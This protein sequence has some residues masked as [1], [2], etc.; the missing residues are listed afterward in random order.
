[1]PDEYAFSAPPT[2]ADGV[3]YTLG[4]GN[5]GILY[6]V[7]ESDGSLLWTANIHVGDISSPAVSGDTVAVAD[8]C[9]AYGFSLA[10]EERWIY[11]KSCT[12][13][14]GANVA[15][16]EDLLYSRATG[17]VALSMA[18]GTA[19]GGVVSG[20][21]PAFAG[22]LMY[23][24]NAGRI[25]AIRVGTGAGRW[26]VE[27]ADPIV[28]APLVM[29]DWVIAAGSGGTVY[30]FDRTTGSTLWSDVIPSTIVG[31][32][33]RNS[34]Q[35]LTGLGAAGPLLVVPATDQ[36]VAYQAKGTWN[37]DEIPPQGK[38]HDKAPGG[39]AAPGTAGS[40][41]VG[42]GWSGLLIALMIG[43]IAGGA[44]VFVVRPR[45]GHA[46]RPSDTVDAATEPLRR[47]DAVGG[48]STWP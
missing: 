32:D 36:V 10:G 26:H 1:M 14:G 23:T 19:K 20:P 38:S 13:G 30:A 6:A 42:F 31:P 47:P 8:V 4:G 29:G 11:H 9:N 41:R 34:S 2:A 45:L 43:A 12:G 5:D 35:P 48:R 27:P 3:V 7:Q 24:V 28:T 16:W 46:G 21:I 40:G 44:V 22:D 33:E 25:D 15:I 39:A 17:G 37:L 18:D